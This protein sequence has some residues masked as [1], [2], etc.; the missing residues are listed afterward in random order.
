MTPPRRR[1]QNTLRSPFLTGMS[2]EEKGF[3]ALLW[4]VHKFSP[5]FI[6]RKKRRSVLL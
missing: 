2:L 3:R 5:I 1:I 6:L 4:S